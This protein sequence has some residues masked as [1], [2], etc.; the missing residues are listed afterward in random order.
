M[1]GVVIKQFT[2]RDVVSRW[3]VVEAH[4]RVTAGTAKQFLARL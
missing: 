2:A 3:D 1:P 4:S